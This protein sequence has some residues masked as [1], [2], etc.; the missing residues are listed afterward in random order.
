[1]YCQEKMKNWLHT[2][3]I[4][5]QVVLFTRSF[6]PPAHF[7]TTHVKYIDKNIS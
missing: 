4:T 6:I 5:H 1:M 2:I 3:N 7:I